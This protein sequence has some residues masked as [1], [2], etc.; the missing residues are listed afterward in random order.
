[1]SYIAPSNSAP[2]RLYQAPPSSAS[3]QSR[4]A[5]GRFKAIS[6]SALI[7][8]VA[9]LKARAP[10]LVAAF[11]DIKVGELRELFAGLSVSKI[12]SLK[13]A[14][15]AVFVGLGA[16]TPAESAAQAAAILGALA[17]RHTTQGAPIGD[18]PAQLPRGFNLKAAQ[19]A[20]TE[21]VR[22]Q[23]DGRIKAYQRANH[24]D[25]QNP[26]IAEGLKLFISAGDAASAVAHHKET[27]ATKRAALATVK[28]F[29]AQVAD[30]I[31][32]TPLGGDHPQLP[33]GYDLKTA[34]KALKDGVR[35]QLDQQIKTF[36][37]AHHGEW[38]NAWVKAG[39][40]LFVSAGEAAEK[41]AQQTETPSAKQAA[42]ETVKSF[43][44]RVTA[45]A[46]RMP[47]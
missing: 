32:R 11:G 42:L 3:Q 14:E 39:L 9:T 12:A 25:F 31:A 17:G 21:G 43:E 45:W 13:S 33:P 44:A 29:E 24:G 15:R 20:L 1:M 40:K 26:W 37:R 7:G 8:E 2:V 47:A 10:E 36:Q 5:N 38:Q 4:E 22:G 27:P 34:Q 6:D 35:T 18:A 23:L 16:G 30:W 41:L 28:S 19:K 46:A